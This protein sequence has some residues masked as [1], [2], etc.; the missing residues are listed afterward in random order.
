[1]CFLANSAPNNVPT[2]CAITAP[3][4]KIGDKKGRPQI[5]EI[6]NIPGNVE[7]I[8]EIVL[9]ITFPK[10]EAEIIPNN[11]EVNAMNGRMLRITVSMDSRPAAKNLLT[12]LPTPIP[13]R[14]MMPGFFSSVAASGAAFV[15]AAYSAGVSGSPS[16]SPSSAIPVVS[17]PAA[18][19]I[20]FRRRFLSRFRIIFSSSTIPTPTIRKR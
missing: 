1:M 5:K 10:P 6:T 9:A 14:V 2:T 8:G 20:F 13:T 18:A 4:P 11:V 12:T 3:G 19:G 17:A 15:S 16:Q 7:H